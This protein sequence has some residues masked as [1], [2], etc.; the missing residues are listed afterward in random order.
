MFQS[1]IRFEECF[2]KSSE[3]LSIARVV[4]PHTA[5]ADL[6]AKLRCS[7]T[8][9]WESS[10]SNHAITGYVRC[11]GHYVGYDKPSEVGNGLASAARVI[12]VSSRDRRGRGA[13]AALGG[14]AI[15]T[16]DALLRSLIAGL[17]VQSH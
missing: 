16:V 12:A 10:Y 1:D 8:V 2:N 5:P 11:P 17:S 13:G 9:F 3:V 6:S 4:T 7:G 15:L 14:R